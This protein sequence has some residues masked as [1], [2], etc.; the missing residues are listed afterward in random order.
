MR[1]FKPIIR[2]YRE[3]YTGLP[4]DAWLLSL[5]EFINRSGTMVFFFMTLYLTQKLGYTTTQ[6]G[7]VLSVYGIGAIIG[8]YL[9]GKLSDVLGSYTVQKVSLLLTA[10]TLI[11]LGQV[12]P[13]WLIMMLMFCLGVVSETLHPANAT[14]MSQICPPATRTRG[15]ALNRLATNLGVTIGP[16]VGGFLAMIDYSYLFWVDGLT[17]LIAAITFFLLFKT[18]RPVVEGEPS[19]GDPDAPLKSRSPLRNL[20][21][22]KIVGLTFLMGL[23]FT[24][25]FTTYPLYFREI[26]LFPENYI[27]YLMAINTVIIVLF[28][29]IL[30]NALKKQPNFY[31]VGI[32]ALLLGGGMA[33]MP[34]GRGFLFAGL[35]VAV[36]TMGEM[37]FMPALT[38][39]IANHSDDSARGS[40]MGF[41]SLAF[42][43]SFTVGP[44][45]GAAVYDGLG[46][47]IVWLACGLCGLL[48]WLGFSALRRS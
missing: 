25:L 8:G 24:Q 19:A 46:K 16:V 1:F 39:E 31:L 34:L 33:M 7:Q 38:T 26:Y 29:M 40:Y 14:A 20:F 15:F 3:A 6:A 9:G 37:L 21:F 35:T 12:T 28:E 13:L 41:V 47:D 42:S 2:V 22:L 27:G 32:G 17:C 45:L 30:L 11:A 48:I 36:W 5:V 18:A 10:G 4:R 43:L 44:A 23:I